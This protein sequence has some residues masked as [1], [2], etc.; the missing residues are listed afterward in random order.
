MTRRKINRSRWHAR[1]FVWSY[2]VFGCQPPH[3]VDPWEY[4]ATIISFVA[5]LICAVAIFLV[6]NI[7]T[8]FFGVFVEPIWRPNARFRRLTF[9]GGIPVI[10]VAVP[11]LLLVA[12]WRN[13]LTFGLM[14]TLGPYVLTGG[15]GFG[16]FGCIVLF[17]RLRRRLP[18]L[19]LPADRPDQNTGN[20]AS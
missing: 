5:F 19:L 14:P 17:N 9:P 16:L 2:S 10:A 20:G 11:I 8:I 3:E 12:S 1:L 13:W 7:G 6:L 18:K 4:G 15:L